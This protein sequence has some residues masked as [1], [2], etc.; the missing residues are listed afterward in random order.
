MHFIWGALYCWVWLALEV[1]RYG[2]D[3]TQ[4][5][6]SGSCWTQGTVLLGVK[7]KVRTQGRVGVTSRKY[8]DQSLGNKWPS[9]RT[10]IW[11]F[12]WRDGAWNFWEAGASC[13]Y[14]LPRVPSG[15]S[16][17]WAISA[18]RESESH[19][20]ERDVVSN[21]VSVCKGAT[22]SSP[23]LLYWKKNF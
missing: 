23:T 15:A 5:T 6:E 1:R 4:G 13:G 8:L 7:A 12:G 3:R 22:F 11:D 17:W 2:E 10:V 19:L 21:S 14:L 20:E 18:S 9:S 16:L